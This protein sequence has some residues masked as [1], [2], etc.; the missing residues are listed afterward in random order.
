MKGKEKDVPVFEPIE[1]Q[2][3]SKGFFSLGDIKTHN[4][5]ID[6]LTKEDLKIQRRNSFDESNISP[7]KV[8]CDDSTSK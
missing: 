4:A 7:N 1:I 2:K 6:K 3:Q 5:A 8:H